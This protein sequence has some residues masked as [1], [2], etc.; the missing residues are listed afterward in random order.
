[1]QRGLIYG[2]LSYDN[3]GN[4]L[5]FSANPRRGDV[6]QRVRSACRCNCRRGDRRGTS[7]EAI[8]G[9]SRIDVIFMC[10]MWAPCACVF[11]VFGVVLMRF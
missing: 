3:V 2:P 1:M 10:L 8:F 11:R 7:S 4:V 9:M 6:F 5:P